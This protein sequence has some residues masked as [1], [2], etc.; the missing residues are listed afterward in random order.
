[1]MS[2]ECR[3]IFAQS[4]AFLCKKPYDS[5]LFVAQNVKKCRKNLQM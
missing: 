2:Y 1:M 5:C 3:F 4:Y